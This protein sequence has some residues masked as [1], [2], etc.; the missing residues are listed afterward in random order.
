[1]TL[2]SISLRPHIGLGVVP[3]HL[4]FVGS[5]VPDESGRYPRDESGEIRIVAGVTIYAPPHRWH[6]PVCKSPSS[7]AAM[8]ATSTR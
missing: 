8:K 4:R 3:T 7:P 5:L 6:S 2:K 1:M